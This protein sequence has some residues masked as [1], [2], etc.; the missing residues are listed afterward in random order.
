[1]VARYS[2]SS[3]VYY[4][5]VLCL[6]GLDRETVG[7]DRTIRVIAHDNGLLLQNTATATVHLTVNDV[8]DHAPSFQDPSPVF[9]V[10]E[11]APATTQVGNITAIDADADENAVVGYRFQLDAQLQTEF[12]AM[13]FEILSTGLLTTTDSLDREVRDR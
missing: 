3:V 12:D 6:I 8:N 1:M 13:P 7:G 11:N 9:Y 2:G 5:L 4:G 10:R